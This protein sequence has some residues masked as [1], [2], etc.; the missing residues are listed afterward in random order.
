VVVRAAVLAAALSTL[1]ASVLAAGCGGESTA[2][3][4]P[5]S[6]AQWRSQ[7]NRICARYGRQIRRFPQPKAESDIAEFIAGV[8]PLWRRQANALRALR[9]PAELADRATTYVINLDY[10]A[11]WLV[12]LHVARQR[13]D[14]GRSGAAV[15]KIRDSARSA[16]GWAERLRLRA[17]ARERIP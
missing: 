7:A 11:K 5:L 10:L 1:V 15:N 3:A 4:A 9:P 12:E 13:N 8:A 17:C 2:T 6:A 16:K 14:G